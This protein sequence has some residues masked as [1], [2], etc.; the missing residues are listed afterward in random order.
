MRTV[1]YKA[2]EEKASVLFSGKVRPNTDDAASL[3]RLINSRYREFFERLFWPEWT[4]VEQRT[5]RPA[6]SAASTYT[7]TQEVYYPA[8]MQYYIALRS[9][10]IST[11]PATGSNGDYTTDTTYWADAEPEYSADDWSSTSAYV[12]GD[13][14]YQPT[15]ATYYQCHTASTNQ[16]PPNATYWGA[17]VPFERDI[18]F[19]AGTTSNQGTTATSIG[20]VKAI[21]PRHPWIHENQ[22]PIA[23]TLTSDGVLV[24]GTA[25][26]VWVEFRLRP[27]D[28]TGATWASGSFAAG[29]QVYYTVTGEY[30]VCIATATTELP[31]DTTKWTKLDFPYVLKDAVAQAAYA[32][33]LKVTGK[34]SKWGEELKE[35]HR[36]LAREFDKIERQQGQTG[37]LNVMTR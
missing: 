29:D 17:L 27:H 16:E 26:V 11:P 2:V 35:A 37:P 31:T 6:Y 21:W 14:V 3:N 4:V 32:D 8:T 24:R 13:Q 18:D 22:L 36:L 25:N 7:A 9:V 33:L 10:P 5:F 34:T 12:E 23:F 15:N 1:T 28:F 30:Y 20:E 19:T